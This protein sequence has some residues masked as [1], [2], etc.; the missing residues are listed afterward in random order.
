MNSVQPSHGSLIAEHDSAIVIID[1]QERLV[2][3]MS[4]KEEIINN[5]EKL[6]RFSR[7]MGIPVVLTKQE[8]L[9]PTLPRIRE[10]LADVEP[11][12]KVEFNCF[13]SEAFAE[14]VRRLQKGVLIVAGIEA[15]I[16][17]AQTALQGIP[18]YLVHVVSDAVSSRAPHN[19]QVAIKRMIQNGVTVT[20]TEMVIYE[21]LGRAGT[22]AFKEV[23][24]LVK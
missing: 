11:I 10:I 20:S 17:V 6:A 2:P 14:Q 18:E 16:C 4:E 9:G 24:K 1:M 7:I 15:H 19:R 22:D 5:V 23:L 3:V 8:K 13:G 21:I 12:T